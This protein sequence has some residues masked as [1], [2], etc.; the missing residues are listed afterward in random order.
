M[1][2]FIPRRL[3]CLIFI[4]CSTYFSYSQSIQISGHVEDT[5][6]KKPLQHSVIVVSKLLDSTLIKYT[7]VNEKGEFQINNLPVDTYQVIISHPQFSDQ[8]FFIFG[9]PQQLNYD[10][11]KIVLPNK[12]HELNEV[13]IYGY[14]DPVYYKGDTLVYTADSFKTKA[15]ATVEDLLKKLP[16]IKVDA[17]GKITSQGKTVDQVLV[18]GDEFFGS[19]PTVAT[20]NLN[21]TSIESVQ[22]YDKKKEDSNSDK[23]EETVKIMNLKL[24]EDAKKGY[25]GKASG[26]SDFQRFYEGELLANKFK[27][28]QK[29]SLFGLASNTPKSSF[30]WNDV[31]K[32]GL[33]NEM[34]S[35]TTDD[36]NTYY[37]GN[38]NQNNGFPQ[39]L[40]S[41]FYF[42]DKIFN[43]TK[44]NFNYSYSNN[45]LK[46]HTSTKSQYFLADTSYLTNNTSDDIQKNQAHVVNLNII[47]PIDSL[48]ELQLKSNLKYTLTNENKLDNTDFN[49]IENVLTR[50]TDITNNK[51]SNNYDL[52]NNLKLTRHFKK[53]DRLL[54]LTYNQQYSD[55][56]SIGLLKTDNI[57]VSDSVPDT[58]I[59][60]K[61]NGETG[62]VSHNPSF[63]YTEPLT[64]KIKL[65]F[66]YDYIYN[67]NR[68]NKSTYNNINGEYSALD[69]NYTNNFK[70]L[71][72]TNRAGLKF[73]YEIKKYRV[74]FGSRV[75]NVSIHNDNIFTHQTINQNINNILPFAT[76]KYKFNDNKNLNFGYYTSSNQ[77]SVNQLQPVRDNTNP[78]F[79]VIGNPN[80]IP[81]FQ[82]NF[83]LNFYS[84]K[85]VSGKYTWMG[86]YGNQTNN[87]FSTSTKYDSI[88]R[89]ISQ[90][91]NVNGNMSV[92]GYAGVSWPLFS[93]A[94][95]LSPNVNI[96][97]YQHKNIINNQPNITKTRS[98]NG[99]LDIELDLEKFTFSLSGNYG[100]NNPTSSISSQSNK[101]Y[102]TQQY[103]GRISAK[104][105]WKFSLETDAT[106]KINNQLNKGYNI[107]YLVWNASINKAFLKKENLIVTVEAYDML[108]QNI[109]VNRN[110]SG[111]IISDTKTNII[112]RYFLLR[113]TYKFNSNKTKEE[114]DEF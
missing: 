114:E 37:Y 82:H 60:Q 35:N 11:G 73:I 69:S 103:S 50:Q 24:K 25:F 15:N 111:N 104:L 23:G 55:L 7:R 28:K 49:T 63:I 64:Q 29:I 14:K 99:S 65:E 34:N 107:N 42:S 62:N 51:A 85:P 44:I 38:N 46:S 17:Q 3:F 32:Y 21:A 77:P 66:S 109:N 96:S 19:D 78:N 57:F 71:K 13:V 100:Y 92:N 101:P 70:T 56:T 113:L 47:Q 33:D 93:R 53:K 106:Y 54:V 40:K 80:L 31:F 74:A 18:D 91:I 39:T 88:G 43:K 94:L 4:I 97:Y 45:Q 27:K 76:F 12:E 36:G 61:K 86:L 67:Q 20:K 16:G 52:N 22:V 41:G 1:T 112:S 110:I 79:L 83:E 5:I 108:N 87:D 84:F 90:S 81:S 59:D 2:F 58:Y 95:S 102:S 8:T 98:M 9:N 6:Q 30:G 105:P 75:R 10:F 26:A 72:Q 68:Q 89:T 48:T